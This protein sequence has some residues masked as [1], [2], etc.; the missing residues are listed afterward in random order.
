M[1]IEA[2]YICDK[3][4]MQSGF[5]DRVFEKQDSKPRL[6]G[7]CQVRF[8]KVY[9]SWCEACEFEQPKKRTWWVR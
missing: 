6:C 5:L 8:K 4:G 2:K 9:E 7:P 1:R 3:C